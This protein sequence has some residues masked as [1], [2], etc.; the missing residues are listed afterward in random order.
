[1]SQYKKISDKIS[2][3]IISG[4]NGKEIKW[5]N[6]SKPGKEEL[7]FLR[8]IKPYDFDFRQLTASS[9][10]I[11]A[12]RPIIEQREKY[13]FL[14]LQFPVFKGNEII[15][16]EVD[17][18]ISHGLLIT[19]QS[20]NIPAVDEFF[21]TAKKNENSLWVK[22]TPSAAILLCELLSRLIYH[23]YDLLDKNSARINEIEKI[24][25]SS[26]QKEAVSA[27]LE[28]RRNNIAIR[29]I[30][31]SHKNILKQITKVKSRAVSSNQI[32]HYYFE[33]IE[34]TKRIWEFS[35]NQKEAIEALYDTNQS[36]LNYN[37]NNVIK[38]LTIFS[39]VMY[40]LSIIASMFG[41]NVENGMPF[42]D[43]PYGFWIVSCI[44]GSCALI[45]I[46]I[47][48]RKKWL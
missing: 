29:R 20:G 10:K 19:L 40:P 28:L 17:F 45:M 9:A 11:T 23:C 14:I 24:I 8:K 46:L 39:V 30:M 3:L 5:L 6:I 18:F 33:L 36:L 31:Q 2:Q 15:A 4:A 32:N 42:L 34:H 44:I 22:K 43:N 37:I 1:M 27:I 38:T 26:R 21:N 48:S 41:M 47:F 12:Q 16:A 7:N 13:F 25:F 35:E